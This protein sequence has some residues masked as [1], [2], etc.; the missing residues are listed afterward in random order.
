MNLVDFSDIFYFLCSRR[1]KGESEVP[2]GGRVYFESQGGG[3]VFQE[4]DGA[5]GP[6]GC[7]R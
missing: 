2:G 1:G 4:G 7:L 5:E 3:G 6:G